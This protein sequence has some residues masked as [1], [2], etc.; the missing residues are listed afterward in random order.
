MVCQA[1]SSEAAILILLSSRAVAISP[2]RTGRPGEAGR[3]WY[4]VACAPGLWGGRGAWAPSATSRS[5]GGASS[6]A[7]RRCACGHLARPDG[8][9]ICSGPG[10]RPSCSP[11]GEA[12]RRTPAGRPPAHRELR[13]P[14]AIRGRPPEPRCR[15]AVRSRL[16]R[17]DAPACRRSAAA[18]RRPRRRCVRGRPARRCAACRPGRRSPPPST[19]GRSDPAIPSGRGRSPCRRTLPSRRRSPCLPPAGFYLAAWR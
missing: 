19:R 4:P 16:P 14:A 13:W 8:S 10:A 7:W 17:S 18:A 12:G 2:A 11:S 15:H 6:A 3:R 9:P 1:M 5:S